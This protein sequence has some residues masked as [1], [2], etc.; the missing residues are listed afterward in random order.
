MPS[1]SLG[2]AVAAQP[3]ARPAWTL[4][5]RRR[6]RRRTLKGKARRALSPPDPWQWLRGYWLAPVNITGC[7]TKHAQSFALLTWWAC[8]CGFAFAPLRVRATPVMSCA[9]TPLHVAPACARATPKTK[10]C[11]GH[12]F[13]IATGDHSQALRAV[14]K[15][16]PRPT[17]IRPPGAPQ[18]T[19]TTERTPST[20][21]T[22]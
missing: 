10:A 12:G 20:G 21:P 13:A 16:E 9:P 17:A 14:M 1:S 6:K 22:S 11:V 5:A 2:L 8:R 7:C 15:V 3:V 19:A 18:R 4:K